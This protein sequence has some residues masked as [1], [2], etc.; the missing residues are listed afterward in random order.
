[1]STWAGLLKFF[2]FVSIAVFGLAAWGLTLLAGTEQTYTE[3][4]DT[5]KLEAVLDGQLLPPQSRSPWKIWVN[6]EHLVWRNT[7]NKTNTQYQGIKW[8]RFE[9]SDQLSRL[10][11]ASL[12]VTVLPIRFNQG[13][14]GVIAG[15][16]RY[17]HYWTFNI[18]N[19]G[20]YHVFQKTNG[21]LSPVYKGKHDAIRSNNP[22]TVSVDREGQEFV[23]NVNGKP[24]IRVPV[25]GQ[26]SEKHWVGLTAFGTGT[27]KF[28][29]LTITQ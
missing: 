15:T 19:N 8:V 13:G 29:D 20:K 4:F 22:N 6:G 3:T 12:A 17:R 5:N 11:D 28:D 24:V 7:T 21:R 2:A 14:A 25:K 26:R 1:M 10:Q 9:G 18:D 16:A 27:Y 23:F